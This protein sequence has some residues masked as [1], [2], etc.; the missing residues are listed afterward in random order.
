MLEQARR[1]YEKSFYGI[2]K[3]LVS[4]PI[5]TYNRGL[6]LVERTL[7][8]ILN[9]TYQNFEIVVVGD[10]C[11]DDTEQRVKSLGDSRIRFENLSERFD[12]PSNPK[13][14]WMVAG[15]PTVNRAL[16]LCKGAWI[17]H[18]DDDEIFERDHIES[19][20][21]FAQSGN[22]ELAY[23]QCLAELSMGS[24]EV[25]GSLPFGVGLSQKGTV[26]RSTVLLRSY[27]KFFKFDINAWRYGLPADKHLWLRMARAGVR[28]GFLQKLVAKAPLRPGTTR[29]EW[30]AEDRNT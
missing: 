6:L 17:C 30:M 20:L 5:P 4:V 22:W 10:C 8:T 3:P 15:V 14:F 21:D 16:D 12:Y 1:L 24:W 11:T 9:Q 13:H 26:P 7:P 28:A 27:L 19:L 29:G 25:R 18:M 23:A 2:E